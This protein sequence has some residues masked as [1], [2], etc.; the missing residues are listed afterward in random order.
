L[1]QKGLLR[2]MALFDKPDPL[3][4]PYFEETIYVTPSRL[5]LIHRQRSPRMCSARARWPA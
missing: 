3:D 5:R 2:V 4:G 1:L